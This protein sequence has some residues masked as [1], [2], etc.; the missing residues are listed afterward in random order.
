MTTG[1]DQPVDI[2]KIMREIKARVAERKAAGLYS[3]AD[4]DEI[5]A[6]ELSLRECEGYGE[7]MDRLLSWLHANWEATGAV[8]PEERA[9]HRPFRESLKKLLRFILH[10]LARRILAKQNQINARIVQLLSGTAPQLREGFRDVE[11]RLDNLA[12]HLEKE[13]SSLQKRLEEA[14]SRLE[15]LESEAG[16]RSRQRQ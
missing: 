4:I 1:S 2:G 15:R 6:M 9:P 13:N 12:L 11:E 3:E 5:A 8:D 10:P 7:E 14:A 16:D